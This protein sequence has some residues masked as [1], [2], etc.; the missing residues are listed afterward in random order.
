MYICATKR[1]YKVSK[2]IKVEI[3]YNF[4]VKSVW[5]ALTDK[6]A[7]SEWLMPCD[8]EAVVG[9][10]FQFKTKP[11]PGF[12]GIVDCEVLA[13]E[14]E[15]FLSYSWSGGSVQNTIVSFKL[16]P[17]GDSA[18]FLQ[19]EHT[20]FEGFFNNLIVRRILLNGWRSKILT[21]LLPKYLIEHE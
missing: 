7:V 4:P 11:Y 1:F 10:Q 18:T 21:K 6:N 14:A 12:N 20:G 15:R 8:I 2:S 17:D 5:H 9:H 19:F 13:V 16:T 3:K